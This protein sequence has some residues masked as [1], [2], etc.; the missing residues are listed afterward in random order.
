MFQF[1]LLCIW[2]NSF[3]YFLF[4]KRKV[5]TKIN[6]AKNT[7]FMVLPILQKN[8]IFAP[9]NIFLKNSI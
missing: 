2:D 8:I 6:N 9:E 1:F 5:Y 3:R 7:L 4:W